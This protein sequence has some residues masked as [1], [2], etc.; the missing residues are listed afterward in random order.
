MHR[1]YQQTHRKGH[2]RYQLSTIIQ[3]EG[4]NSE[5]NRS[6]WGKHNGGDSSRLLP[7][8]ALS[9]FDSHPFDD[10]LFSLNF[11]RFLR[12][13]LTHSPIHPLS[14]SVTH[15]LTTLEAVRNIGRTWRNTEGQS[16][17]KETRRKMK[18]LQ[19]GAD[20][21]CNRFWD[22]ERTS[23][24]VHSRATALAARPPLLYNEFTLEYKRVQR[25]TDRLDAAG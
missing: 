22:G 19:D 18:F 5:S 4:G 20:E 7:R 10:F 17:Q 25:E 16:T 15:S 9:L 8:L 1:R 23:F 2:R 12:H 14:Y 24:S 21:F 3:H 11:T 13:S 6:A